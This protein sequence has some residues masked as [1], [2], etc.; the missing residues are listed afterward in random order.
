MLKI[1]GRPN[2]L[3]V[4]K[5]LWLCGDIAL[6]FERED[7][8]RDY[9][10][11]TD[12][13][14]MKVS[15]YGAVPVIDDDGFILRESNTIVRYLASRHSRTDLYPTDLK[16]RAVVEQWMDHGSTEL[17][18]GMAQV[19]QGMVLGIEPHASPDNVAF[20]K[21]QWNKQF[22][23][24]N[25]HLAANGPYI[26]GSRF[27]IGDIPVGVMVHRWIRIDFE[28]PDLPAVKDYYE[29]LSERPGYQKYVR[30]DAP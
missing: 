29:R 7:W 26:T 22:E 18:R 11:T 23:R 27:T 28:K 14:F 1:Y 21:S 25:Q 4:R 6:P 5:V 8:G 2:S 3:N 19:F 9:R 20:G 13:E 16:Q 17:G 15:I 10:P 12:P 30:I 24:L